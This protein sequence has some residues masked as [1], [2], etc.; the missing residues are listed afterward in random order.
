MQTWSEI[1]WNWRHKWRL[2]QWKASGIAGVS[3]TT[4]SRWERGQS[5]PDA[6]LARQAT[7]SMADYELWG[8]ARKDQYRAE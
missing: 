5:E 6:H 8:K 2:T 7:A 1:C 4:W 3:L